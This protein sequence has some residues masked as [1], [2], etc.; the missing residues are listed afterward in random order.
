MFIRLTLAV[1]ALA[2]F[3]SVPAF[4]DQWE[5]MKLRGTV[6][7][8]TA[9]IWSDLKRGDMVPDD[10]TVRTLSD[11]RV[12]LQRDQEVISLGADTQV[13]VHD[14]TRV[15]YTTVQQDFGSVEVDAQVENVQH[16][17]VDTQF[18][19]A[20][21]KGTHF[22]VT[23]DNAGA[24]VTV[25]RGMVAVEAA[26]SHQSTTLSVGQ[27]ASIHAGS[28]FQLSGA[29]PLPQILNADGKPV[30]A[31]NDASASGNTLQLASAASDG[32]ANNSQSPATAAGDGSADI[33]L[34]RPTLP[35]DSLKVTGLSI[36]LAKPST[37]PFDWT[38]WS[39][40]EFGLV[41]GGIGIL[42]GAVLGGIGFV[43]KRFFG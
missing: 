38:T 40:G 42:I 24:S 9:G 14:K 16:F 15:R 4:A 37:S 28:D 27:T 39:S 11:G 26:A 32:Q 2:V 43:F 20:V 30:A 6:Q 12:D 18:L 10:Q 31:A 13:Q 33:G 36:N 25:D 22:V 5:V 7:V 1:F 3:S 19:A 17:E 35:A 41:M 29:G 23:A 8:L 34:A 21:V